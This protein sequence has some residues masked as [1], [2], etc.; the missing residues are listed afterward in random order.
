MEFMEG[1]SSKSTKYAYF[2]MGVFFALGAH[3]LLTKMGGQLNKKGLSVG[4]E[5]EKIKPEI[6]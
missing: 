2:F 1:S 5:K 4:D 6:K 3:F